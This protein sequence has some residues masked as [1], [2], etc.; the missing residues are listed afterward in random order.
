MDLERKVFVHLYLQADAKW[1]AC[2]YKWH[3]SKK[4]EIYF[5]TKFQ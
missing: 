3:L 1:H 4:P 2:D 5:Y